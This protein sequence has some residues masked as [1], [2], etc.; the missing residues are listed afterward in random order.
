MEDVEDL[1]DKCAGDKI[2]KLFLGMKNWLRL[3]NASDSTLE[4]SLSVNTA[5]GT[6]TEEISLAPNATEDIPIHDSTRFNTS[7]NT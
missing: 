7:A 2:F 1:S 3:S 6:L 4:I 5:A